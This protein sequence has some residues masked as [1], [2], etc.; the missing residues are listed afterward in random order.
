[1]EIKK[2]NFSKKAIKTCLNLLVKRHLKISCFS[3]DVLQFVKKIKQ[4]KNPF[5][6]STSFLLGSQSRFGSVFGS[7]CFDDQFSGI[8]QPFFTSFH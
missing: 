1:M 8:F 7:P 3:Y 6:G 2:Y 5:F 4:L